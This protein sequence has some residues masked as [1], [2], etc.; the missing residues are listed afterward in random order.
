MKLTIRPL[1][2]GQRGKDVFVVSS[3]SY[4]GLHLFKNLS[5]WFQ[6]E[7]EPSQTI[8]DLKLRISE[9]GFPV[10]TQNILSTGNLGFP[11]SKCAVFSSRSLK[12]NPCKMTRLSLRMQSR[13]QA[14][15][16]SWYVEFSP[17]IVLQIGSESPLSID[18]SLVRLVRRRHAKRQQEQ[19]PPHSSWHA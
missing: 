8:R 14:R 6:V 10:E 7:A 19:Q 16:C 13:M 18:Q 2:A 4:L 12:A 15:W 9:Q 1:G 5:L 3:G 11:R 17:M